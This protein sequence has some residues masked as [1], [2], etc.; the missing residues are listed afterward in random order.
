MTISH[1]ELKRYEAQLSLKDAA[2]KSGVSER[3]I[4]RLESNPDAKPSVDVANALS[5]AYGIT[6]ADLL[7][8]ATG[9]A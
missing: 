1:L 8:V 7:N 2:A 3:T 4:K 5:E 9:A 6:V